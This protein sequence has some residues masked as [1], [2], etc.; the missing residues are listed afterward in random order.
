VRTTHEVF[1][2]AS[3][4]NIR[5]TGLLKS[6]IKSR[7]AVRLGSH[8]GIFDEIIGFTVIASQISDSS[9]AKKGGFNSGSDPFLVRV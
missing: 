3:S 6:G 1:Q 2:V 5:L 8:R 9:S 7:N 4:V